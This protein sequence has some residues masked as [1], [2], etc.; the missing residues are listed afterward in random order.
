[1]LLSIFFVGENSGSE[2]PLS[3]T[4]RFVGL[5]PVRVCMVIERS[6]LGTT[7]FERHRELM[8]V[9]SEPVSNKTFKGFG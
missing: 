7:P 4:D 2:T 3:I 6:K 8:N 9:V 5:S 1:M